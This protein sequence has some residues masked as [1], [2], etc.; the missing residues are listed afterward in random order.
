MEW[1]LFPRRGGLRPYLRHLAAFTPAQR[2][3]MQ[4][5]PGLPFSR[6]SL[7]QQQGFL[8]LAQGED[9]NGVPLLEH[10]A[11][12]TM[13]VDYAVPGTYEWS[14]LPEE[15]RLRPGATSPFTAAALLPRVRER[16][17]EAALL[18]ARRIDPQVTAAQIHPTEPTLTILYLPG[19][20]S[21]LSAGGIHI[22]R[23]SEDRRMA[24]RAP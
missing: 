14:P 6:M 22:A 2:R 3:Q 9:R 19:P 7:A 17:R 21:P 13:R 4:T 10:L 11:G 16:S 5:L 1:A 8:T 23:S 24:V 15:W 20:G 12:A 18:A